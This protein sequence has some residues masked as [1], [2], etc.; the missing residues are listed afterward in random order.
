V[1]YFH[2]KRNSDDEPLLQ[3]WKHYIPVKA[4]LSDLVEQAA[5]VADPTNDGV[6]Q[7]MVANAN[8][9]C[10]ENMIRDRV[11]RDM[12]D[13]WERYVELLDIGSGPNWEER[14]W[15]PAK[16]Q[17]FAPDSR[18]D[19][20]LLSSSTSSSKVGTTSIAAEG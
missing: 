15:M 6:L 14:L 2:F 10:R 7:S 4:D 1:D 8:A 9:W 13:I 19:M 20:I 12:L 17:I 5:F 3:P 16:E 18:L 11:A